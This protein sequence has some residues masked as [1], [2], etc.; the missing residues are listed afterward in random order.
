LA[1]CSKLLP[2]QKTYDENLKKNEKN[3]TEVHYLSIETKKLTIRHKQHCES[4][5]NLGLKMVAKWQI[6]NL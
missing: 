6:Q 1:T 2:E 5:L 4:T 3:E